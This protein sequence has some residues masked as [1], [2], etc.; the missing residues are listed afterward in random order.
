MEKA[1]IIGENKGLAERGSQLLTETPI[2]LQ[3]ARSLTESLLEMRQGLRVESLT[4]SGLTGPVLW[5][6]RH[7]TNAGAEELWAA[8]NNAGTAA[9]ARR[10]S[11]TWAAVTFSDTASAANLLYMQGVSMNGKFFLFYDSD[12]NRLHVWDGTSVRRVGLAQASVVTA[13]T[14]GGAGLTFNRWYRKRVVVQ[15]SGVVVRRSEPSPTNVNVS[16]TDDAG[17]TVTRGTVPGEGETHWEVEASTDSGGA[18]TIWYRIATVLIATTT[19]DDTNSAITTFEESDETGLYVPPPSAKYG[20]TDGLTLTMGGAWETSGTSGQ[21]TPKQ[22]RAWFTRPLGASDVSDDEAIPNT[23]VQKNWL[24]VGDAGPLTAVKGPISGETYVYKE[25]AYGKLTPTGDLVSPYAL[26]MISDSVGAVDGRLVCT[27]ELAGIPAIL[28]ADTNAAYGL[29]SAGGVTNISED[30]GRDLRA[31][32]IAADPGLMLFDPFQRMAFLQTS[33]A[34]AAQ[35]GSY[36]S[37]TLDV[38]KQRWSGFTLGGA[39]SGWILGT[40]LLGTSTILGGSGA[41]ILNGTFAATNDGERRMYVCGQDAAG[42]AQILSWGSQ[43][44][45]DADATFTT[46]ARFRKLFKPGWRSTVGNPTV[47]YRNPQGTTAGTLTLT[48]SMTRDFD[49]LRTQSKTLDV[50]DDDNGIAV[51]QVTFEG[52]ASADV[53]VLDLSAELSYVGTAYASEVTPAIDAI[54]VPYEVGEALAQ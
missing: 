14:M 50:T 47:W 10:V 43:C 15:E 9:L 44:A 52:L 32:S 53:S 27:G 12:V 28:F 40:G 26:S 1:W 29:S 51:K 23:E 25:R 41:E 31:V 13:A 39:A 7:I 37:F 16:I 2:E 18:P 46:I 3:N 48:L 6:G 42:V 8:A 17:V 45:L 30:I 20:A 38:A 36:R 33:T 21:T 35:A 22:N 49:E 34:P 11:G 19:S 5:C 54:V 4:G 24:D